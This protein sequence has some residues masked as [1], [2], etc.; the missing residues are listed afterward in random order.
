MTAVIAR[1]RAIEP[2][3]TATARGLE[4]ADPWPPRL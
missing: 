3:D 4:R 1:R 2:R